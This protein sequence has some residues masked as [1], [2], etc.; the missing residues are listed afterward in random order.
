M[1]N[2]F[3]LLDMVVTAVILLGAVIV[4]IGSIVLVNRHIKRIAGKTQTRIDDYAV[5]IVKGPITVSIVLFA[6]IVALRY[7]DARYPGTIPGW[8][9][10]NTDAITSIMGV[11]IA[12]SVISLILNN[13]MGRRIESIVRENPDR[14][15]TFRSIHRLII[16]AVYLVGAGIVLSIIFPGLVG[17][18]WS[19]AIGAG[20]L[21]IVIGL[22]AQK[23][24]GNLLAGIN[25]TI[26]RPIRLGDAI[27]I[28]GEF[29]FVEEITLR[30]TVVRVWDNRRMIIPNSV[31]DDEVIVNYSLKDP[32][33]LVP[34]F[35]QISYESDIDKAMKIMVDVA[36]K[37][38]DCLPI[39]NLPNVVLM[40]FA[41][42]GISLRLLSR[43]KDQPTAF[44]M[45][46]DL[47]LQIK[48]EFDANG[49]EIPY[50][51][52][53]L[54]TDKKIE[55]KISKMADVLSKSTKGDV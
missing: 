46:R 16:Y 6:I 3:D 37:H 43:A 9:L 19:L 5:K 32:T 12:I 4:A 53:Y 36:K 48:K 13:Y 42:S 15:T 18:V 47:L 35:V 49:I 8:V 38:P 45:A 10:P 17:F 1:A 50:P 40:E 33:M 25:I 39:G 55:D 7:W 21:A 2:Q 28:K 14:E 23:L 52:R 31:L 34:V 54:V 51:R 30:H 41:D 27:V 20:F 24:I 29:G 22:G 44:M 26:T 11:L